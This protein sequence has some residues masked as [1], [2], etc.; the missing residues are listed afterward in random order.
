MWHEWCIL[1]KPQ[2]RRDCSCILN[3]Q[4]FYL[5]SKYVSCF[6]C[7]RK[8]AVPVISLKYQKLYLHFVL[9][10]INFHFKISF[11]KDRISQLRFLGLYFL[12][13]RRIFMFL[14]MFYWS[15]VC[16]YVYCGSVLRE[17]SKDVR[18]DLKSKWILNFFVLIDQQQNQKM[19]IVKCIIN[20]F[21]L[22]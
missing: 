14:V 4:L 6:A 2:Q 20:K 15:S 12:S 10:Q 22:L 8:H 13:Q 19:L 18:N 11:E 1:V 5:R 9:K 21:L 17:S 3:M 16:L 7:S